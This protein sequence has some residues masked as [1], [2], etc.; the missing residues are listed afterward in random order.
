MTRGRTLILTGLA[1]SAF[2][3]NSLLCRLAL[4]GGHCDPAGFTALRLLSGA[5]AL[6]LLLR[7]RGAPTTPAG[8]WPSALALFAYAAGF[9][10]GYV[11]LPAGTGALLLF[12]AVQATMIG[13]GLARG[14][15]LRPLQ[16]LGLLLALAGLALLFVPGLAAPPVAS[17][18]MMAVA[19]AAWGVY[20]IRGRGVADPAAAT[21]GNFHRAVPFA[22]ALAA[23]LL[24]TLAMDA[25]GAVLA[26]ASGALTSGIGY[27]IWYRAIAGLKVTQAAIAQLG[28][29]VLTALGAVAFLGEPLTSGLVI[30]AGL[31]LGGIALVSGGARSSASSPDR[32]DRC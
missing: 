5:L 15:R 10:F 20:S 24:P 11:G 19:G 26:V 21:A 17:A 2:A 22:A 18:C 1:V 3:G 6:W 4:R 16:T 28:V 14:E 32:P 30:A 31:V 27:I 29:P 9:S 25:T 23:A 7:R 12:G 8:S 13:Y